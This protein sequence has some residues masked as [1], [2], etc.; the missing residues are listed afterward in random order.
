MP[1]PVFASEFYRLVRC[2]HGVFLANPRDAYI[3]RSLTEYGEF[4]ELEWK[5]LDQLVRPGAVVV[6]A[7]ANIGALT[8][9]IARKAGPSG[10]VYAIEP[11]ILVFQM[12]AANLAL[13]DL[14]N[15]VALNA[16]VSASGPESWMP[17]ARLNP[18]VPNNFGGVELD[19]L[20][21]GGSHVRVRLA[22]LDAQIDPPRLDLIKA[23]VEGME[24]D[25]LLGA[26]GLIERFRPVLYV[27]NNVQEKSA[28]LIDCVRGLGYA[29]WWHLP[30]LF[31]PANH[32]GKS[33]NVFGSIVS[34]N[35]LALPEETRT[36][37]RGLTPVG[38][39]AAAA[40]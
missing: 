8:V 21:D 34:R 20:R 3:G 7:G 23:D 14:V 17:I 35:M 19:Q 12:L 37:V 9:P 22:P 30:P 24:R 32:A 36:E 27:E 26:S 28:A 13:N 10:L 11:Q 40:S 2:R 38:R 29:L 5:L 33:E 31:N 15:T 25:V 1:E 6:E 18:E 39:N 4:S 16:A